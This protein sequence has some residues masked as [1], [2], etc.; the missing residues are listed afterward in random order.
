M[1]QCLQAQGRLAD[2]RR[3]VQRA[4]EAYPGEAQAVKL[5][6]SLKLGMR[7]PAGALSDLQA[8]ERLLPGD[9]PKP[10]WLVPLPSPPIKIP[11]ESGYRV[12]LNKYPYRPKE[13]GCTSEENGTSER[14]TQ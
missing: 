12:Y 1:G 11:T 9:L 5:G 7:D 8:Y 4:R 14:N 10:A 3:L 6:A 2:A 13:I